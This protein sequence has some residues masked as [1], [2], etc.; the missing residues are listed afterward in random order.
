MQKI[1]LFYFILISGTVLANSDD[2]D[3]FEP[4]E[5][6][7]YHKVDIIQPIPGNVKG[8]IGVTEFFCYA[9]P[10]CYKLENKLV[11][12]IKKLP[13]DASFNRHPGIFV[14][15]MP[16]VWIRGRCVRAAKIH[17]T[18]QKLN[19]VNEKNTALLFNA[20]HEQKIDMSSNEATIKLIAKTLKLDIKQVEKAYNSGMTQYQIIMT[21]RFIANIGIGSVPSF[22]IGEK[23]WT[24]PTDA[25]GNTEVLKVI[26]YLIKKI[27]NESKEQNKVTNK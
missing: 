2:D 13:E 12:W 10:H 7:E 11:P 6:S 14:P 3:W 5:G 25:G 1:I 26:D 23:Y 19:I 18:T 9:C 15:W 27:R 17:F 22:V 16:E 24:T 8:K 21:D 20:I 4:V